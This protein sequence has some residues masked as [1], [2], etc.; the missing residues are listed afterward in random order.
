M[1]AY[2]TDETDRWAI[3]QGL[4]L[5]VLVNSRLSKCRKAAAGAIEEQAAA[6]AE[7]IRHAIE[8][9]PD[10]DELA[11]FFWARKEHGLYVPP[12]VACRPMPAEKEMTA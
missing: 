11:A 8:T 12:G 4:T 3:N 2:L 7:L 1:R 5:A 6:D 10:P 9:F